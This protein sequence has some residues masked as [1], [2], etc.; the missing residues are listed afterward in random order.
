MTNSALCRYPTQF[1][2]DIGLMDVPDFPSAKQ[3]AHIPLRVP[4]SDPENQ[5]PCQTSARKTLI[6]I[7]FH[8]EMES[9]QPYK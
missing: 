1:T 5:T 6:L 7:A 4:A 8:G 2:T 3:E 9:S